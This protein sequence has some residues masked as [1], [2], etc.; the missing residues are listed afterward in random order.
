M[1]NEE[2]NDKFNNKI[3][4]ISEELSAIKAEN[5]SLKQTIEELKKN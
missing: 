1:S 5:G 2:L 3:K 4:D